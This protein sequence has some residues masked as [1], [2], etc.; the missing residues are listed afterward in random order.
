MSI[1]VVARTGLVLLGVSGIVSASSSGHSE[2]SLSFTQLG[3]YA[4][5]APLDT[6]GAE[7]AAYDPRTRRLFIVNVHARTI[8]I[9]DISDPSAPQPISAIALAPYGSQANSVAVRRGIVAAAVQA[10]VKTDPGHAVFFDV[11]GTFL[12]QVTVGSQPDMI[13]FTPDGRRVLVA[14]EGEPND[15]YDVD[16]EGSASIIDLPGRISRLTDADVFTAR[17]TAFND[18]RLDR[19][20]RIFGP[21]ATV[22]QDLEPE[23]VTVS[24]DSQTA[25]VVLQENNAIAELDLRKRRFTRLTG[26]GFKDHSR[27]SKGLDASDRDGPSNTGRVNIANWPVLGMYMPDGIASYKAKGR[28]YLV[29]ANEGDARDYDGF[30]EEA[31]VSSLTL[32]PAVFPDAAALQTNAQLGR[33]TVTTAGADRNGDGLVDRLL[34]F[35]GRSFSIWSDDGRQVFDSGDAFERITAAALPAFFN[36]D[37]VNNTSFDTRSD[38]KG[39]EPEGVAVAKLFGRWYAFVGLERIGGFVVADI[40]NPFHPQFVRYVNNRNFSGDPSAGTAGDLGPEGLFVISEEDSPTR[41][42]LLVVTHEV[43]GTT[44][45]FGISKAR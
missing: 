7:V 26:L 2:K 11:N 18:A 13:T 41:Q 19:S 27:T 36:S 42:P 40:T 20:I 22:A 10:E 14:N 21:G 44:T 34:A 15:A 1:G 33:L 25:W 5:G 45:M 37:H 9:V 39:P 6:L 35:G 12:A 24:D 4:S 8:D 30:A 23:H 32:D 38:N 17:F 16:P 3:T 28:T 29:T 43:S 31:R